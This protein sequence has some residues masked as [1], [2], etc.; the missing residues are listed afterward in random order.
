MKRILLLAL[1]GLLLFLFSPSGASAFGIKD[2]LKMN[3]DG[4]ADSLMILKIENSG[5]TF[6]L[7]ADDM[8]ALQKAGVS[9]EVISAML[10]TEGRDRG[11]DYYG[12]GDYYPYPYTYPYSRAYLGFGYHHYYTPYYGGY[13][14]P[15]YRP[16]NAPYSGNYGNSRYRGS[17]GNRLP[18]G[19]SRQPSANRQPSGGS[20]QPSGS[21]SGTRTRTR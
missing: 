7:S 12:Y 5:K 16:Y 4:I 19:G 14:F 8:Y 10:R 21:G 17:Y 15:R 2:V 6:H 3:R 20:R 9:D 1:T 11:H 18:S 13:R